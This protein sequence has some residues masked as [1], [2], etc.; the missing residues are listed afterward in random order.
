MNPADDGVCYDIEETI[1]E[2]FCSNAACG[3]PIYVGEPRYRLS[4]NYV[5]CEK[6]GTKFYSRQ[7]MDGQSEN[8]S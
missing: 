3:K 2:E 7:V 5:M 1:P 8:Q 4:A 6:C